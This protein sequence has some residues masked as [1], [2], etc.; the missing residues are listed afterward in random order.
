MNPLTSFPFGRILKTTDGG[1]TW[2][3]DSEI[4]QRV[5]SFHFFGT[6]VGWAVGNYGGILKYTVINDHD[7]IIVI[8][9]KICLKNC[10]KISRG[11]TLSWVIIIN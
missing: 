10:E 7:W 3:Y 4:I 11:Q 2:Q 8:K 9:F 1:L 5:N 6:K